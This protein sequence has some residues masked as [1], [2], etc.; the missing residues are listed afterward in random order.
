V[1][2]FAGKYRLSSLLGE[3]GF[4]KVYLARHLHLKRNAER[5]IKIIKIDKIAHPSMEERFYR[6]VQVTSDLSQ[7]NEHIV[8]IFDDFGEVPQLGHFYV[9]E[10]LQGEP[11]ANYTL[12]PKQLAP[13]EW[14][15]DTFGQLCEAMQA[16][17]E[18]GIIH[19]D[20][21]PDNILLVERNKKSNFVK[22]FDF[23]IAKP[24][25]ASDHTQLNLTQGALGTPLYMPPEQAMNKPIDGRSDLYSMGMILYEL[26][27]G[28]HPFIPLG[29]T[30]PISPF[31]LLTAQIM[32]KPPS[33][34]ERRPQSDLPA[35]TEAVVMK[36]LAKI[37]ED[38]YQTVEDMWQAL[39]A[40]LQIPKYVLAQLNNTNQYMDR[41]SNSLDN[42][43][44]VQYPAS[45]YGEL[46]TL[47]AKPTLVHQSPKLASPPGSA[48][49][50]ISK[51]QITSPEPVPNQAEPHYSPKHPADLLLTP[52]T[53]ECI[54]PELAQLSTQDDL[55][56]S[57]SL[58]T[59][60]MR[61]PAELLDA[62]AQQ[63]PQQVLPPEHA[64]CAD[65]KATEIKLNLTPNN[66]SFSTP[67]LPNHS[68]WPSGELDYTPPSRRLLYVLALLC[69]LVVGSAGLYAVGFFR[70]APRHGELPGK[71]PD[72][73][74]NADTTPNT[75]PQVGRPAQTQPQLPQAPVLASAAD[76]SQKQ[77]TP[78][79][80]SPKTPIAH[81]TPP[82][83]LVKRTHRPKDATKASEVIDLTTPPAKHLSGQS[84]PEQHK[85]RRRIHK[86]KSKTAPTRSP[87]SAN[88]TPP[89]VSTAPPIPAD[90]CEQI[91]WQR[92]SLKPCSH[93]GRKISLI[94][95]NRELTVRLGD[96][97]C[98][99]PTAKNLNVDIN[100]CCEC[101]FNVPKTSI[102][103]ITL[104]NQGNC[105]SIPQDYC[106][107][108]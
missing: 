81:T 26:L 108:R 15:M 58:V 20:L 89:T 61:L 73:R 13:L 68:N 74:P 98:I 37:P 56:A 54:S 64:S 82:V 24:I 3:G 19:R 18:E 62:K 22:I 23:G 41:D 12:E 55:L 44:A 99:P 105:A 87:R 48:P 10:Y 31:E 40:S 78:D 38:R 30:G 60:V 95:G 39:Y 106:L 107:K 4:G 5:V 102:I 97:I 70:S 36:A 1:L 86:H 50:N 76:A 29:V 94:Y 88:A 96:K 17:H 101:L 85:R 43:D 34:R 59:E 63:Q 69:L 25:G 14:I 91:G 52:P 47:D 53:G 84:P 92:I 35:E 65:Q 21:K 72:Q 67:H 83:H 51:P 32:A 2:L 6:E 46:E 90:D 80:A 77:T 28:T 7:R 9:M 79:T 33:I 8:R 104:Q 71:I 103:H 93:G 27:T 49:H 66:Q 16:A 57:K 75:T 100:G 45:E 11:L 42:R